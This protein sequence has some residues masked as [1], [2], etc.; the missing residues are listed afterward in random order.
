MPRLW[1]QHRCPCARPFS[2]RNSPKGSTAQD[3]GHQP[4]AKSQYPLIMAPVSD[5]AFSNHS[6]DARSFALRYGG[7]HFGK[8][9]F[10]HGSEMLYA[11][12]LTEIAGASGRD[13]A[14]TVAGGLIASAAIDI[15]LGRWLNARHMSLRHAARLQW[16]GAIASV[17]T[18]ALIAMTGMLP[19]SLRLAYGLASGLMFRFAYGLYDISQN[20]M[21]ALATN[22]A[23]ERAG[24][25]ALRICAS[26]CASLVIAGG[27][28]FALML[29]V[30]REQMGL[31]GLTVFAALCATGSSLLLSRISVPS[32]ARATIA[33][34]EKACNAKVKLWPLYMAMLLTSLAISSFVRLEPYYLASL[35]TRTASGSTFIMATAVGLILSQPLWYRAVHRYGS[36]CT[37]LIAAILLLCVFCAFYG[38][39]AFAPTMA[40]VIA[41]LFGLANGGVGMT[42]WTGFSQRVARSGQ[43]VRAFGQLTAFSKIGLALAAGLVGGWLSSERSADSWATSLAIPMALIPAMSVIL[44]IICL[45]F[46]IAVPRRSDC[47]STA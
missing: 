45:L 42:I 16:I 24:L 28:T 3:N 5:K 6:R 7:A 29:A 23:S 32:P 18:V 14:I 1:A 41:L 4:V 12:F 34:A 33:P 36:D 40:P 9:L 39:F 22:S 2:N 10:W 44:T 20:S 11:F 13:M 25:S 38:I 17:A 19:P 47:I 31:A 35:P 37:L 27:T 15:W 43:E 21:L 46:L 8:S 26:G 30:G